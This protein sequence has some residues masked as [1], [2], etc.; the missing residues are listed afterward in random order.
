MD[1]AARLD[2]VAGDGGVAGRHD[3]RVQP[4]RR[5]R[6]AGR[7]HHGDCR[8]ARA[9]RSWSRAATRR[10]RCCWRRSSARRSDSCASISRRPR[11]SWAT[12]AACSRDS[13]SR[14]TAITGW[15]K[16]AT[17]LATGVPLMIFALPIADSALALIRRA[18]ARPVGRPIDS[19]DAAADRA[20]GSRTHSSPHAGAGLV[21]AAHR[22]DPLRRHRDPVRAR[23]G[24]GRRRDAMKR[25]LLV[26]PSMQPPGG[27][28]GV[29]AWMLQALV[30]EH[31]VTVLSWQP[32]EIDPINRFFGTHL[33]PR[34][35]RHDRGAALVA[36]A[37]RSP[38]DAL[39]VDQAVAADALHAHGQRGLRRAVRRLQRNRLRAPRHSIR[40]LPDVSA[41]A[42]DGGSA[43]VSPAASRARTSITR[44]P[45]ASPTSRSID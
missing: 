17:A 33:Q 16:G 11:S 10:K 42:A 36:R 20:A 2:R 5:R 24:D 4:D 13:C 45:I 19:L 21:G 14:R 40:P 38:S 32:V 12:A 22:A 37:R 1:V 9:A 41:A 6:R 8:R 26:Q 39:D 23:A 30:P 31:R 44:S 27:G 3:Q 7:R 28:N 29:A 43:L 25:V 34:R 35:F 15:Q 18:M